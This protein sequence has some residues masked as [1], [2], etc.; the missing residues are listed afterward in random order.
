[1]KP[2]QWVGSSLDDHR[3]LPEPIKDRAGF[4]LQLVQEGMNP[5]H[6]RPMPDVGKG[7]VE[8]KIKEGNNEFR[9]FYVATLGDRVY[10][11]HSFR[12]KTQKTSD[13]DI[14]LG[15]KRYA[16]AVQL[17]ADAN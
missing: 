11:L 6:Y 17:A 14:K 4:Q 9:V 8:I 12:K 15:K 2:V 1:M 5:D 3:D 10:V 16:E 13:K 7:V